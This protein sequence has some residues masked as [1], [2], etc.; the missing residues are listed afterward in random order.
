LETL[1]A[2]VGFLVILLIAGIALDAARR[3]NRNR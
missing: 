2:V 1:I 3:A